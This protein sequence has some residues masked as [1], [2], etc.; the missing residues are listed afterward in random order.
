MTE[1]NRD[2]IRVLFVESWGNYLAQPVSLPEN[3][4]RVLSNFDQDVIVYI[5][6]IYNIYYI[7]KYNINKFMIT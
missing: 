3:F 7:H 1:L 2:L 5:H 4:D 6:N